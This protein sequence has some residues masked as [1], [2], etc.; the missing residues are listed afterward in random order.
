MAANDPYQSLDRLRARID[1]EAT[2]LFPADDNPE[3]RFDRLLMGEAAV[4]DAPEGEG[5]LGLE[6]E[7]RAIIENLN[8]DV[9]F[10]EETLTETLNPP[11]NP[12]LPLEYPIQSIDSVEVR[13][14]LRRDFEPL[15]EYQYRSTEHA[16]ILELGS[17]AGVSGTGPG[18]HR[19]ANELLGT[20][21]RR[22]WADV[23]VD[24]RVTYDRGFAEIPYDIQQIQVD[25]INRMIRKLRREQTI[26]AASP[27]EFEG[28]AQD[29]DMV[30]DDSIRE[31]I[32]DITPPGAATRAL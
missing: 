30:V 15:D 32:A 24:I 19:P 28:A 31:R 6:A 13:S 29:M 4:G 1:H 23:A 25:L 11:D 7:A 2:E 9:T 8:G 14:S 12:T 27:D 16:L 10:N 18:N 17:R 21:T 26:A 20:T 3:K 22:T 5:W